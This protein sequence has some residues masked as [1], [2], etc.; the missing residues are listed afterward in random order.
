RFPKITETFVLYEA[1]ALEELG[2]EVHVFPLVAHEEEV[3]H[4]GVARLRGR[5]VRPRIGAAG[6]LG[7]LL[8]QLVRA[9]LRSLR[10]VLAALRCT[11]GSP[12]HALRALALAPRAVSV[13]RAIRAAGCVHVHAHFA[14]HPALVARV[15]RELSGVGYTFTAHGSDLHR[16]PRGLRAKVLGARAAITVSDYNKRFVLEHAG[17]DLADRVRVLRCGVDLRR[18]A[19]AERAE[20]PS[21][22]GTLRVACVAALRSVKGHV[23][24]L[25]AVARCAER[26]VD[27]T[28]EL[29]GD[30]PLRAELEAF[31]GDRDL[32]DRVRFLGAVDRDGIAALL[33]RSDAAA[34][35]SIQDAEGRREGIPVSLM[36][37]M[38]M[39]LP[40]VASDLSGIPELIEDGVH[41]LLAPPGDAEAIAGAL[42]SLA[43]NPEERARMGRRGRERVAQEYDLSEN[44]VELART[45]GGFVRAR[46]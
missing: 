46:G 30:G 43:G 45:L 1:L 2:A 29:A 14:T 21:A 40:V 12:A 38:A 9:P 33:E 39:E 4:P 35:T 44:A 16:D 10:A 20:R 6:A 15:V 27:V 41:G 13:A 22:P 8:G 31:V 37:A 34:L 5:V 11:G 26:G 19:A 17:E 23:H 18:F 24:L 42:A 36:E 32:E 3:Q 25:E 7:L 28:L